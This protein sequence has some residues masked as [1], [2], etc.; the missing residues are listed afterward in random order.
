MYFCRLSCITGNI[1]T[2]PVSFSLPVCGLTQLCVGIWWWCWW[3]QGDTGASLTVRHEPAVDSTG[4][5]R[6]L[7]RFC[8]LLRSVKQQWLIS[9][10]AAVT[11]C[12]FW[13]SESIQVVRCA[14]CW[15]HTEQVINTDPRGAPGPYYGSWLVDTDAHSSAHFRP[16]PAESVL[17]QITLKLLKCSHYWIHIVH[18]MNITFCKYLVV[19]DLFLFNFMYIFRIPFFSQAVVMSELARCGINK[20]NVKG[21]VCVF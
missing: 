10:Q 21:I 9:S 1:I 7:M 16:Q 8:F 14:I 12:H 13:F 5:T 19:F 11:R 3:G 17:C 4:C 20:A 2:L 18:I 15:W 6:V